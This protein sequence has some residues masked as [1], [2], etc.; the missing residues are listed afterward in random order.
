[1]RRYTCTINGLMSLAIALIVC[2]ACIPT[3]SAQEESEPER[4]FWRPFLITRVVL[5]SA[6]L[7][8]VASAAA[9]GHGSYKISK[10]LG[11][12]TSMT[13]CFLVVLPEVFT[14]AGT[15]ALIQEAI[16]SRA[17]EPEQAMVWV[18][19]N[20]TERFTA[21]IALGAGPTLSELCEVLGMREDE[22]DAAGSRLRARHDEAFAILADGE[23]DLRRAASLRALMWE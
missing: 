14:T 23:L 7:G 12:A 8:C 20:H 11:A 22:C 13:G 17:V 10:T 2:L 18:L 19:R 6:G 9:A 4:G 16:E 1:M 5:T 15:V 21:D 3:A